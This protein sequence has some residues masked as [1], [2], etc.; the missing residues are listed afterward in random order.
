V[1]ETGGRNPSDSANSNNFFKKTPPR[2]SCITYDYLVLACRSLLRC[3]RRKT[4]PDDQRRG[5]QSIPN[6][7]CQTG[8]RAPCSQSAFLCR[9]FPCLPSDSPLGYLRFLLFKSFIYQRSASILPPGVG[10]R[11]S[12]PSFLFLPGRIRRGGIFCLHLLLQ[13]IQF[14]A[15]VP[16]CLLQIHDFP[17]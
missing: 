14:L 15:Q 3:A 1:S 10:Q 2:L 9:S 4:V 8:V 11:L 16:V 13:I 12:N 6:A 7:N 17:A 5:N